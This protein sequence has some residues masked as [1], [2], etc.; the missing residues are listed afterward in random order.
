MNK[1]TTKQNEYQNGFCVTFEN[2]YSVSVQFGKSS[3]SNEG[4]STAE[5]AAWGPDGN[6][7]KINQ[8]DEVK[9]HC[10]PEE[11]L[12]IMNSVSKINP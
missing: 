8:Y 2:G 3:Y 7:V 5:I 1:F 6:W 9:P 12:D 11:M 10:T 4:V